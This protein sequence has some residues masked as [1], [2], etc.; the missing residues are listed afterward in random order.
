MEGDCVR[1]KASEDRTGETCPGSASDQD[2]A[3][4][5]AIGRGAAIT[6]HA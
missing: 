3:S 4:T 2:Q 5:G 1:K 6:R